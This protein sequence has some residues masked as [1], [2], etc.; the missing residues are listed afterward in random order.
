[1]Y[2]EI[3]CNTITLQELI[4]GLAFTSKSQINV[5][6]HAALATSF[7]QQCVMTWD[8]HSHTA[9]PCLHKTNPDFHQPVILAC[10]DI[11]A[12]QMAGC[13]KM[14]R[15]V[16]GRLKAHKRMIWTEAACTV[17]QQ[18]SLLNM[19][20][21]LP[22]SHQWFRVG[23]ISLWRFGLSAKD[24]LCVEQLKVVSLSS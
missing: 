19:S 9:Q 15:E 24:G 7:C 22:S 14:H 1:M 5:F 17:S 6:L 4:S 21:K 13:V 23:M 3:H 20:L 11:L 18:A 16:W 2:W 12:L 8:F 10:Q